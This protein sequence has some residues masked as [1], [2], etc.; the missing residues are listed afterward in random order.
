MNEGNLR[1]NHNLLTAKKLLR[2][3]T[4]ALV[5]LNSPT[6]LDHFLRTFGPSLADICSIA[7]LATK[8]GKD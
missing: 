5:L 2:V 3:K 8:F 1:A 4:N 6:S 7:A